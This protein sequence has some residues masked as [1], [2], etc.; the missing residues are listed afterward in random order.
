MNRLLT[1]DFDA[2]KRS[3]L[4]CRM[5]GGSQYK[6]ALSGECQLRPIHEVKVLCFGMW[7][8]SVIP[9]SNKKYAKKKVLP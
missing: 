9:Y 2:D 4:V 5:N 7:F 6:I 1:G 8:W 3:D